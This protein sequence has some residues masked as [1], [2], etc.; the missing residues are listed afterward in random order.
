MFVFQKIRSQ[1]PSKKK[2]K[3]SAAAADGEVDPADD[4]FNFD[5]TDDFPIAE[6][7]DPTNESATGDSEVVAKKKP[8]RWKYDIKKLL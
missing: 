8:R 4:P 3:L 2:A 7:T 5:E 1:K 6:I